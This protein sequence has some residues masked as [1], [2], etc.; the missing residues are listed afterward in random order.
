MSDINE[1]DAKQLNAINDTAVVLVGHGT[2]RKAYYVKDKKLVTRDNTRHTPPISA[3]LDLTTLGIDLSLIN[4][5]PPAEIVAT[6]K[7]IT[8]R[9]L[10]I[11]QATVEIQKLVPEQILSDLGFSHPSFIAR[12]IEGKKLFIKTVLKIQHQLDTTKTT[13]Q[14][15]RHAQIVAAR[16]M[17][18]TT[19]ARLQVKLCGL[20]PAL[21]VPECHI[22]VDKQKNYYIIQEYIEG[23]ETV[24]TILE[25]AERLNIQIDFRAAVRS[26]DLIGLA[27]A[28][29]IAMSGKNNDLGLHNIGLAPIPISNQDPIP[30]QKNAAPENVAA[31]ALSSLGTNV[32]PTDQQEPMVIPFNQGRTRWGLVLIDF[33]QAGFGTE[34]V[35]KKRPDV[36]NTSDM[37]RAPLP[38]LKKGFHPN[39]LIDMI[40]KGITRVS[41]SLFFEVNSNMNPHLRTEVNTALLADKIMS[42]TVMNTVLTRILNTFRLKDNHLLFYAER[43]VNTINTALQARPP[44]T[45]VDITE[46]PRAGSFRELATSIINDEKLRQEL[47]GELS[48]RLH[49]FTCN[50][51]SLFSQE[52]AERIVN[53]VLDEFP[54]NLANNPEEKE[55]NC[56]SKCCSNCCC[57][58][59]P[60][61]G[62]FQKLF[63]KT[64]IV[65]DAKDTKQDPAERDVVR[66]SPLQAEPYSASIAILSSPPA[67]RM[68]DE[69]NAQPTAVIDLTAAQRSSPHL[70]PIQQQPQVIPHIPANHPGAQSPGKLPGVVATEL[71]M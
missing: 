56:C 37:F 4:A 31:Q 14:K 57:C 64:N 52:T 12:T 2:Q 50:G 38:G 32:P 49:E 33:E 45:G 17:A 60:I 42:P 6:A 20:G 24:R 5:L 34:G 53:N 39:H 55:E 18:S 68:G 65:Q 40:V 23:L 25:R 70:R 27:I 44:S 58:C 13:I 30:D 54:R 35:F 15:Q 36:P 41:H 19:F 51:Q 46:Q 16:E 11:W 67:Q 29:M 71:V 28:A 26:G 21:R 1:M 9:E 63:S 22:G 7:N 69:E 47:V 8:Q 62:Y 66:R 43:R 59:S 3:S 48:Q 61:Y 10:L